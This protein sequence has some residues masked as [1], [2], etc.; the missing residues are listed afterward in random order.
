LYNHN[1]DDV[2]EVIADSP[3]YAGGG[4]TRV[5]SLGRFVLKFSDDH[6]C[7][8]SSH[9]YDLPTREMQI[10]RQN[11]YGGRFIREHPRRATIAYEDRNPVWLFGGVEA[12]GPTGTVIRWSCDPGTLK[13]S[14]WHHVVATV[15]GGPKVI[16]FV[17]DGALCDGGEAR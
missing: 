12:D 14:A 13:T 7:T 3:S 9:R 5:D 2:R 4:C 16:S 17:V 15:D 8:W 10:D 1:S 6:G 11:P